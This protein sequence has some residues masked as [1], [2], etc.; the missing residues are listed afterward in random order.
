MAGND[1]IADFGNIGVKKTNGTKQE[2]PE[3]T[4]TQFW[5]NVGLSRGGKLVSLPMGIPLDNL[6]A[7]KIPNSSTKNQEFRNLRLA[8]SQLFDKIQEIMASLKPGESKT[9]PLQVELRRVEEQEDHSE[10]EDNSEN[11]FSVGDF[12]V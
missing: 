2:K 5:V 10:T 3:Q 9:L 8:E 11:P 6:K 12:K 4:P 1:L 7:R